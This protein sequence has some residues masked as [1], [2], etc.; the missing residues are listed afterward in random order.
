MN[1]SRICWLFQDEQCIRALF[2][3]PQISLFN[4]FF[5]KNRS[6]GTIHIFKNNFATI[7]SVFNFQFQQ[8]KFYSNGSCIKVKKR[9]KGSERERER[10][11][12]PEILTMKPWTLTLIVVRERDARSEA[13]LHCTKASSTVP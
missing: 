1:S 9:S 2:M 12:E 5:I 4:S 11:R 8:N 3:N 7:F 13:K 10:E 6:H